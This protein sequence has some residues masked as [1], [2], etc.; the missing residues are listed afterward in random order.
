TVEELQ[1]DGLECPGGGRDLGQHVDAVGVLVDHAL[2]AAHLTLDSAQ[3]LEHRVLVVAVAGSTGRSHVPTI[4]P[5]G[6]SPIW[7]LRASALRSAGLRHLLRDLA[8]ACTAR[9]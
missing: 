7:N 4:P 6:M 5:Y 3:P 9:E 2:Q 1:G 8:G